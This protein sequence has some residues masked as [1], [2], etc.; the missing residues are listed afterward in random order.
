VRS[1]TVA[2]C[3]RIHAQFVCCS[4]ALFSVF[5]G[6]G[7]RGEDASVRAADSTPPAAMYASTSRAACNTPLLYAELLPAR[8]RALHH[9]E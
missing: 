1:H 9:L 2:A 3:S 6:H 4:A 5:D 8:D 7:P